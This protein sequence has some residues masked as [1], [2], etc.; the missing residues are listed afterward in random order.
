MNSIQGSWVA[1]VTPMRDDGS[2]DERAFT[3][4]LD[5]HVQA[6]TDGIV[7]AGT[8][9]ESAALTDPEFS[10]LVTLAV[11]YLDGR[12]PVMAGVG[13]PATSKA[14]KLARLA[15]Q[16]GADCLLC[17]TPYYLRTTQ[18]GL[19]AHYQALL[20]VSTLPVV[21]YNVPG[22]TGVD[23]LPETTAELA[24]EARII[25][26]KEAVGDATRVRTL[27]QRC[28]D[29]FAVLSGDDATACRTML[30]GGQGVVSVTANVAPEKMAALCAAAL[31]GRENEAQEFNASLAE[32]HDLLMREP[33]PMPVKG[34]LAA[35]GRIGPAIRL[36]LLPASR[37]LVEQIKE[38][39][40]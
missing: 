39:L 12:L 3:A 4:L 7:V 2:I 14:Q 38:K 21:L 37:A 19:A 25:G 30:A 9:G 35:L 28:P 23:L 33:N 29:D 26:I 11:S 24:A 31:A 8:T 18:A 36:P 27:L 20:D 22:R 15:E 34:V 13:A 32:V 17:V 1:I 16:A 10:E 6:G 40:S 5:W